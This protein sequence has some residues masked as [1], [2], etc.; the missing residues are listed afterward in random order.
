MNYK[1]STKALHSGQTPDQTTGASA[2]PLYQTS[3]FVFKDI[4][5]AAAIFSGNTVGNVYSRI[6]NPTTDVL[7][8]R[9]A[10]FEGGVAA[11]AVS[12]GMA[13]VSSTFL[14]I[15]RVGDEIVS[16]DNLYGGSYC[17]LK[18]SFANLGRKVT[19]VKVNDTTA[20]ENAIT[21]RTKALY[22]E[23][24]GNPKL[25]IPD[26]EALADIA[27]R[28][29]IPL[30]VDNT[31]GVGLCKTFDYGADV[32]IISA[33]K[34][35]GGHGSTLGGLIVDSGKFNWAN[36]KF[37]ELSEPD[38]GAHGVNFCEKYGNVSGVGNIAFAAKVRLSILINYGCAIS[39]FNSFMLL[40]GFETLPMRQEKHSK[41]ALA[42]SKFL[43]NHPKVGWVNYPGLET[44]EYYNNS[45]KYF[46]NGMG[47]IIC[48]GLKDGFEGAK[49]FIPNLKLFYHLANIG[50][51]RSLVIH[52]ASTTHSLLSKEE[53]IDVG[54]TPDLIRLSIGL[55]DVDD[56]IA[57]LD[58]ALE[59]I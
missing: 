15:T 53:Q 11:V 59:K 22:V 51:A 13:A 41:N 57:D 30:I 52:P 17:W 37:P 16:A 31:I 4:E 32:E 58:Q 45:S 50:D 36:G 21:E 9:T 2:V 42:V 23:F 26:L 47:G 25:E 6:S 1:D 18:N 55:E 49:K 34:Y 35:I 46:K 10:E 5:T 44:N 56:I 54:I 12:S 7:E 39:P 40:Q 48:F 43:L 8:Q 3:S 19:F 27:H 14:A 29:G 24:I 38:L 28:H 33:T 20:F